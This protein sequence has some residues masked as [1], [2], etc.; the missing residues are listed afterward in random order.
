MHA[1]IRN[2]QGGIENRGHQI[3]ADKNP[4]QLGV[5]GE[6]CGHGKQQDGGNAQGR[7]HGQQVRTD[8]AEPGFGPV[9]DKAHHDI[10]QSIQDLG[11]GYDPHRG[12]GI[13]A[14]NVSAVI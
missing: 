3:V 4:N 6:A 13:H 9:D 5:E 8:L 12:G 11:D 7:A 10:A 1:A 14:G 2:I